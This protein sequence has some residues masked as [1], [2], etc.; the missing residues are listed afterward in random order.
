MGNNFSST[1][2]QSAYDYIVKLLNENDN[3]DLVI[4]I[5]ENE[6]PQIDSETK[7]DL[8]NVY[9]KFSKD[10]N[11]YYVSY[12][13]TYNDGTEQ[14]GSGKLK[15]ILEQKD[16]LDLYINTFRLSL[17]S[18]NVKRVSKQ[19]MRKGGKKSRKARKYKTKRKSRKS[20]KKRKSRKSS[21]KSK[22]KSSKKPKRKSS[23]KPK[24]K[25]SKKP[26][27]KSAKKLGDYRNYCP[28]ILN[29]K[30]CLRNNRRCGWSL[31]PPHD[32]QEQRRRGIVQ[33]KEVY[34]CY[35]RLHRKSRKPRKSQKGGANTTQTPYEQARA[36]N[37]SYNRPSRKSRR[38]PRP[39]LTPEQIAKDAEDRAFYNARQEGYIK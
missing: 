22:R 11:K 24:R 4:N 30:T 16:W 19:M 7:D 1:S 2:K 10:K 20:K 17:I 5:P 39:V 35:R 13:L 36:N 14:V 37:K 27:R 21:K 6:I 3:K 15:I 18:T 26:K 38:R 32:Y 33:P 8:Y 31:G 28:N 23:K 34:R 29:K 12:T 9:L 25:S